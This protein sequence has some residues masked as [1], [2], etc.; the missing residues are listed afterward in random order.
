MRSLSPISDYCYF[1]CVCER[2]RQKKYVNAIDDG[3]FFFS[4]SEPCCCGTVL[5]PCGHSGI[6]YIWIS[7]AASFQCSKQFQ[8]AC[9]IIDHVFLSHD[10]QHSARAWLH[11][12]PRSLCFNHFKCK[13]SWHN[14]VT[15]AEHI[16]TFIY[17]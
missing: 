10:G 12:K 14:F 15:S 2:E 9:N 8:A 11:L 17:H 6:L 3:V 16:L 7:T 1:I 4:C 5:P 13:V